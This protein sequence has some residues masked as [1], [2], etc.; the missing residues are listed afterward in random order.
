MTCQQAVLLGKNILEARQLLAQL[1]TRVII[2]VQMDF[3]FAKTGAAQ[4]GQGIDARRLVLINRIEESV[5]GRATVT[6]P[7]TTKLPRIL[8]NPLVYASFGLFLRGSAIFWLIVIGK[9]QD[10]MDIFL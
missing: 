5:A 10:Q 9:T 1:G 3:D 4:L 6:I 7:E 8:A 2:V